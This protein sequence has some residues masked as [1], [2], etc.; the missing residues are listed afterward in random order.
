MDSKV[1]A[2][3]YTS[4]KKFN[5]IAGTLKAPSLELLDLYNSLGFEELS[6]SISAF[7]EKNTVEILDGSLDELYIIFGKLQLLEALGMNVTEGIKRVCENNLSK[8]IPDGNA[9]RYPADVIAERNEKYGVTVLRRADGKI[10]KPIGFSPVD[11]SDLVP[12]NFFKE[13]V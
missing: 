8:F 12:K 9:L 2:K 13:N 10:Q 7:E 3:A 11:L 5:E 4:V 6:E 1:I